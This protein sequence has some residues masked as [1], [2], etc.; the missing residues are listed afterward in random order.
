MV[1][2]AI[3]SELGSRGWGV[4]PHSFSQSPAVTPEIQ[5]GWV[6]GDLRNMG[7][8]Q[9]LMAGCE[10]VVMA[11]AVSG[12]QRQ[13]ASEPWRQVN[14]NLIMGAFVLE[15]AAR[16]GVSQMVL[17]GSATS[18]QPFS[19]KIRE[20]QMDFNQDPPEMYLGVGWV[21]RYLERAAF[22]WHRKCGLQ[23]TFIRAANVFGPFA[24]F[25]PSVS[26]FIPALVRKTSDRQDPLDLLGSAGVV[27][28]VIFSGD[29]AR[30]LAALMETKRQGFEIYN[31]GS[32]AGV[33][34][35]EVADFLIARHP[36]Y[37]PRIQLGNQEAVPGEIR[38]RILDITKLESVLG[39]IATDWQKGVEETRLWWE[40]HRSTWTR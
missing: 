8:V 26:N 24:K 12:G 3:A 5:S 29:F 27:R 7:D 31:L 39:P 34:V 22:F 25:D 2:R 15:A 40:V 4:R 1:G 18:Y 33:S 17:I 9:R 37:R 28:D 23:V 19:G 36:G 6:Q 30:A 21:S 16:A 14:D 20:D 38:S 13:Q 35:G 10:A 11:A 32:G